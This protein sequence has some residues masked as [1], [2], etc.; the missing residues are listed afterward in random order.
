MIYW[1]KL[2]RFAEAFGKIYIIEQMYIFP[3]S[4]FDLWKLIVV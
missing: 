4:F 2:M 3:L 1:I